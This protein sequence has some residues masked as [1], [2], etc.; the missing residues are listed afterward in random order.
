MSK[1][2]H[3]VVAVII[4]VLSSTLSARQVREELMQK[5]WKAQWITGPGAPLN[6][7]M[8]RSDQTLKEYGVFKFRKRFTLP[9]KPSSFIVHVSADNRY[10]LY[11]N[12]NLVSQ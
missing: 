9:R 4:C 8:V 12:D 11:V 7:W 3:I 1:K 5:P 10:K 2:F 6:R